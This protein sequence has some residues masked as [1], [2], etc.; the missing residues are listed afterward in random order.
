MGKSHPIHFVTS[1]C[2]PFQSKSKIT[3]NLNPD[4]NPRIGTGNNF[5]SE[6]AS[7]MI[8]GFHDDSFHIYFGII[9]VS[10]Y[11][12][13]RIR[14]EAKRPTKL[15]RPP[16]RR[17]CFADWADVASEVQIRW[18]RRIAHWLLAARPVQ[19]QRRTALMSLLPG[20]PTLAVFLLLL[21]SLI[22]F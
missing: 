4:R 5:L 3:Q 18:K 15:H 7:K 13:P 12:Q 14:N 20:G 21:H 10:S 11:C 1:L 16:P 19:K 2:L 22:S 6:S 17:L 9:H 8:S